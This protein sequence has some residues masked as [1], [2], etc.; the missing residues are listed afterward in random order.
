MIKLFRTAIQITT[1][2]K[3]RSTFS[4]LAMMLMTGFFEAVGAAFLLPFI[5]VVSDASIIDSNKYLSVVYELFKFNSSD[6]FILF[7][8]ILVFI[9]TVLGFVFRAYANYSISKFVHHSA[10]L[11]GKRLLKVYLSQPYSWFLN[12]HSASLSKSLLLDSHYLSN[13][14]LLPVFQV[15]ANVAMSLFFLLVLVIANPIVSLASVLLIG[16]T[17]TVIYLAFFKKRAS[18]GKRRNEGLG[19]VHRLA[20]ETLGGIKEIKFFGTE[21]REVNN[22]SIQA[23]HLSELQISINA[24]AELPAFIFQAVAFG[25]IVA[26][27]LVTKLIGGI[28]ITAVLPMLALYA[29]AGFRLIPAFQKIYSLATKIQI[30]KPVLDA[31]SNDLK[32]EISTDSSLAVEEGK[33]ISLQKNLSLKEI[34]YRYPKSEN[35]ILDSLSLEIKANS[36]VAFVGATGAGKTT[37]I[38]IILGLHSPTSGDVFVDDIKITANNLKQWQ[39]SI[40]YVPQHIFL[41]DESFIKNIAFGVPE[42][43]IDM[44]EVKRAAQL[45]AVEDDILAASQKGYETIIGERGV[46]LSG[47]QRQRL[48][49]ARAL[50]RK[51]SVLVLDEATNA[52]D[53]ETETFIMKEIKNMDSIKTILIIS[54]RLNTLKNCDKIY[55]FNNGRLTEVKGYEHVVI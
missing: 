41:N 28:D 52:L 31:V 6:R 32:F 2:N 12:R 22:F 17:Y 16:L 13:N 24:I 39:S 29:Y 35:Q 26:F 8:G 9:L 49:I 33:K 37:L 14:I 5:Y 46:R 25:G 7:L 3:E 11:I 19:N 40:G 44:A 36:T 21:T 23:R 15:L 27:L 45:A 55:G 10:H 47:G 34:G 50:Y 53:Y 30:S 48:G 4:L 42:D 1:V 54:H 20:Q 43:K 18:A 38:D 51:P